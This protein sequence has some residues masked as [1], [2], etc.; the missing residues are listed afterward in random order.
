MMHPHCQAFIRFDDG[1]TDHLT[2]DPWL[3]TGC[4]MKWPGVS[5]LTTV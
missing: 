4:D 3:G 2:T 5:D 1:A